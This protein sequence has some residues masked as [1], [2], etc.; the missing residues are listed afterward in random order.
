MSKKILMHVVKIFC[1]PIAVFALIANIACLQANVFADT[2]LMLTNSGSD[3]LRVDNTEYCY[4]RMPI[5]EP[6]SSDAFMY[7]GGLITVSNKWDGLIYQQT[8]NYSPGCSEGWPSVALLKI[9]V[10]KSPFSRTRGESGQF[11]VFCGNTGGVGDTIRFFAPNFGIVA[12][13]DFMRT[14]V[15]LYVNSSGE[16]VAKVIYE[17]GLTSLAMRLSTVSY[18]VIYQIEPGVWPILSLSDKINPLT[19]EYYKNY[20]RDSYNKFS[21]DYDKFLSSGIEAAIY[22]AKIENQDMLKKIHNKIDYIT[23]GKANEV[24]HE[25][26]NNLGLDF[27]ME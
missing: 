21:A 27:K 17:V 7:Y 8:T 23:D 1:S 24:F 3:C 26:Q 15:N 18:T 11:V 14:P 9:N 6:G 13:L 19:R 10:K 25:L 4:R 5:Y 12:A 16:Y 22:A 20:A 2:K